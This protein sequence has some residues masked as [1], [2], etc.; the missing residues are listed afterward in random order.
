MEARE[1]AFD[2]RDIPDRFRVDVEPNHDHRHQQNPRKRGGERFGDFGEQVHHRHRQ[3]D[4][5]TEHQHRCAAHPLHLA[6]FTH[7]FKLGQLCQKN[8][9]RKTVHKPKHHRMRD[10][11]DEL[12]KMQNP[13]RDLDQSRQHH[14]REQ[15]LNPMLRDQVNHHDRHR[16]R[17][18]RDHPGTTTK[19]RR[20]QSNH[21]RGVQPNQRIHI[22][23][24]RK[25]DR[26]GNKR[27]RDR[28][29]RQHLGLDPRA[30]ESFGRKA[31][32]P[33]RGGDL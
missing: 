11:A 2:R 19:D 33:R 7:H 21:K 26:L 6:V 23:D 8:H 15:I 29:S 18:A 13:N 31:S 32:Q 3:H 28:Q 27:Q 12:P 30:E 24:D 25:R 9:N 1:P 10:N 4:K 14:R 22:R 5:A 17:R 16:A 20:E